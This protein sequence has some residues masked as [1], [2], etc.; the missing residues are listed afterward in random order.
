MNP[1]NIRY[2]VMYT[3]GYKYS[4]CFLFATEMEALSKF[5]RSE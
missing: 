2:V 3:V 4:T 1:F 5:K